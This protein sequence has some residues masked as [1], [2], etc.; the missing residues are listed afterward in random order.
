MLVLPNLSLS[1]ASDDARQHIS[2]E[3]PADTNG[4]PPAVQF[5]FYHLL[6]EKEVDISEL[7]E[8]IIPEKLV[9][10]P[11]GSTASTDGNDLI[12]QAGSFRSLDAAEELRTRLV[13]LDINADIQRVV[14]D[15]Q[16]VHYRVR[17]GPLQTRSELVETRRKLVESNTDYLLLRLQSNVTN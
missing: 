14:I 15:G 9:D 1:P 17:I 16:E 3:T 5:E 12:L 8:Q 11:T 2:T 10:S 13:L 7:T 6:S 4:H